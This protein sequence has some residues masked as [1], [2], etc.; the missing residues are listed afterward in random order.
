[1]KNSTTPWQKFEHS[2]DSTSIADSD[3]NIICSLSIYD[4]ATEDNQQELEEQMD[5]NADLIVAAPDLLEALKEALQWTYR[6]IELEVSSSMVD[7][8]K[9]TA[10]KAESVIA[11]VTG[12]T[13]I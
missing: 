9:A 8:Q 6:A 11:K 5:A 4:E 10:Q 12:T 1:M 3:G 2:W 7:A 13:N